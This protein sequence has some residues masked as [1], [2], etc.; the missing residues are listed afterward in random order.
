VTGTVL[1]VDLGAGTSEVRDI[2]DDHC[3][4]GLFG[5]HAL[6]TE[7]PPGLPAGHP[8]Q[9]LVFGVG[10]VAG[11]R[12]LALPRFSVVGKSPASGGIGESRVEGPFGPALRDTPRD[13]IV[14]TG[15]AAQPSYVVIDSGRSRVRTEVLAAP[16][17]WGAD[18][19]GVTDLLVARHG[20]SDHVAAIGPAGENLMAFAG[21]VTDRGFAAARMGLGAV[22]GAKNCK[23]IVLVGGTAPPERDRPAVARITAA[24][25]AAIA[26]TP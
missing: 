19:A 23:A 12:A 7:T 6:L 16:E 8:D 15:R 2:P 13:A 25:R 3:F 11:C 24:Y 20:E 18:T 10:P 4:P 9:P 17:L 14:L 22:M 26:A 21:I 5:V 1:R